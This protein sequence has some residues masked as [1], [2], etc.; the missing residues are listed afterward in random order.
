AHDSTQ[1]KH[2]RFV[3]WPAIR[4]ASRNARSMEAWAWRIQRDDFD[5]GM[6]APSL[7]SAG[8]PHLPA[9]MFRT[10]FNETPGLQFNGKSTR[11]FARSA[12]TR[13]GISRDARTRDEAVC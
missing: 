8:D 9:R 2:G 1:G 7:W 3:R 6:A 5:V 12:G 4:C 10:N 13:C 11:V